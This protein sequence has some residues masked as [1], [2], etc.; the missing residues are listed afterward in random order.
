M[1]LQSPTVTATPMRRPFFV[2]LGLA[3]LFLV[4]FVGW[5]IAMISGSFLPIDT[6]LASACRDHSQEHPAWRLLMVL[7][8]ETGGWR[9]NIVMAVVGALWLWWHHRRRFAIAW[10]LIALVAGLLTEGLK[11]SVGRDRPEEAIRD[12]H[13]NQTTLSYPSGHSVSSVVAY[14]MLGFALLPLIHR[15]HRKLLLA[16]AL[17][18]LV[19]FI[20]FSRIYLRAHWFSDVIGGFLLGLAYMHVCLTIYLWRWRLLAVSRSQVP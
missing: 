18:T 9:A 1:S 20:G 4:L 12:S 8:T 7:V 2:Y 11:V 6:S 15:R 16:A 14:G 5:T 3:S 17:T 13:I 10:C 19:G